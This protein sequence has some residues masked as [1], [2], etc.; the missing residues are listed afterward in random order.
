M[1]RRRPQPDQENLKDNGFR[2]RHARSRAG[3]TPKPNEIYFL[4]LLSPFSSTS[5]KLVKL[6]PRS[7]FSLLLR[8]LKKKKLLNYPNEREKGNFES[9]ILTFS[10]SFSPLNFS[11]PFD[12]NACRL[13]KFLKS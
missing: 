1:T 7:F 11:V 8:H 5:D 10:F 4:S 2:R 13:I 3:R 6:S 9:F 12:S